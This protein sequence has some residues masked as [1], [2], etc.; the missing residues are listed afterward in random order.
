MNSP[1]T[2]KEEYAM[3]SH[4]Y[5]AHVRQIDRPTITTELWVALALAI[6]LVVMMS[7]WSYTWE[8]PSPSVE[9]VKEAS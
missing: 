8:G 1:W 4:I 9:S 7:T 3:R 2:L 5:R 6:A